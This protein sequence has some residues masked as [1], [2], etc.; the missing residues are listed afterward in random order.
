MTQFTLIKSFFSEV[1]SHENPVARANHSFRQ[2][3]SALLN[4]VFRMPHSSPHRDSAFGKCLKVP[5][6]LGLVLLSCFHS[7]HGQQPLT[8]KALV[9]Q[10][11]TYYPA[12]QA[13]RLQHQAAL[14]DLQAARRLYWPTVTVIVE[15]TTHKNAVTSP[16][17]ALQIEQTLWDWGGIKSQIAQS[18]SQSNQQALQAALLQEEV[19]LQLAN[20]WQNLLASH[21]RMGVAQ[22]TLERL[23]EYEAQMQRR[24]EAEASPRIDLELAIS[25]IL[26]TQVEYTTAHNSLQ[27][28][29]ARIQQ[30]TGRT[31]VAA[32]LAR[33]PLP[34][35]VTPAASFDKALQST[36]W[37]FVVDQHPAMGRAKAEADLNQ[38]LLDQKRSEALPQLYARISQPLSKPPSGFE[39]GPTAFVGLRYNSS[40][41]FATHLQAQAQAT[42]LAGSQEQIRTVA[43]ELLQTLQVEQNEYTNAKARIDSLQKSVDGGDKVLS[44]YQRQFQGGRKS[45]QDLLNAV[46]ELAQNQYALADAR[47]SLQGAVYRLQIRTGQTL[48]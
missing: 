40:A 41:G 31:D 24:V 29:I 20:A 18:Q 10:A 36:D 12:L 13:A 22:Q 42:R 32:H 38:A 45:W 1:S 19:H 28:A 8:L 7:A 35:S 5:A 46:R 37:Q 4:P 48:Q 11:N 47:A 16:T 3:H 21:E 27:Q 26:Q 34:A 17:K 14:Q 33:Q 39:S 15:G 43:T 23:K 9:E 44:S 2:R 6:W 30:Y 25:R